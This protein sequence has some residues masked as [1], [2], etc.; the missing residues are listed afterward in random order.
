M[1]E[2]KVSI[3]KASI[4]L[5]DNSLTFDFKGD[6]KYGLD[7]TI[8]NGIRR[9]LLSSMPGVAFRTI[10]DNSDLTVVTNNSSLHNEFLLHRIGL[11]PLYINPYE[12]HKNL[13]FQLKVDNKTNQLKPISAENFDIY[14]VK[15]SILKK[16]QDSDDYSQLDNFNLENYNI[17]EVGKIPDKDKE[18]IFRPF[19]IQDLTEYCMIT[20]LN[21]TKSKENY[22]ELEIYGSPSISTCN[23]DVKWQTVSCV[24][25]SFKEDEDLFVA[26]AKEKLQ[27]NNIPDDKEQKYVKELHISEGE[28]YFHRDVNLQPYWYNFKLDTQGYFP[29]N[30]SDKGDGLLVKA[31][32]LLI[33]IFEGLKIEF[34]KMLD[35]ESDSIMEIKKAK[36]DS[37]LIYKIVITGGDDTIGSILQAHICNK[38]IDEESLFNLC[39]YK[40]LHP[41][42]E[43]ITFTISLNTKNN[44]VKMDNV[45]KVNAIVDQMITASSEV[46]LIYQKIND[47]CKKI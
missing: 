5:N 43:I 29:P 24:T 42:E 30:K 13:L 35:P 41:L 44:I 25:Y 19:K 33:K 47:E 2:F 7:K 27:V 28:R 4:E 9:T 22:Q 8:V 34:K 31:C 39:G 10:Q 32:D 23:E 21:T 11:I 26:I 15:A 45:Q 40:K 20:E 46:S 12:W 38:L 18:K 1:S 16:C 3:P 14:K 37:D 36:D 17:S 6:P